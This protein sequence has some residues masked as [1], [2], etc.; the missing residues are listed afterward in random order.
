MS[1]IASGQDVEVTD[2][3]AWLHPKE[4]AW[5]PVARVLRL[6]AVPAGLA[7]WLMSLGRL[8]RRRLELHLMANAVEVDAESFP[9]L[10]A[11][12]ERMRQR[13]DVRTP[14]RVFVRNGAVDDAELIWT[15]NGHFLVLSSGLVAKL[16][17]RECEFVMGYFMGALKARHL[18]F[19]SV[20]SFVNL[21]SRL[22]LVRWLYLPLLR[23]TVLSGD[24]IGLHLCGD[25][26]AACSG[27]AKLLF[28]DALPG[29]LRQPTIMA[30]RAR[31]S[32]SP[33]ASWMRLGQPFPFP[34][35]RYAELAE[36][37][38]HLE[39]RGGSGLQERGRDAPT[40]PVTGSGV[41]AGRS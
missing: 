26:R 30:Q 31:V 19:H 36:Y 3:S 12:F 29:D 6:L 35:E 2:L 7:V 28:G 21:A 38:A 25:P 39:S 33:M 9:E 14:V 20:D 41:P 8:G 16:D 1:R 40:A 22:V 17:A 37:A 18:H 23:A 5:A 27:L 11:A 13:L 10:H 34:V 4:R 24:R 15:S 32:R